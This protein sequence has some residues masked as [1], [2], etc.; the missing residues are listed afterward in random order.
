[1]ATEFQKIG[2]SDIVIGKS[3]FYSNEYYGWHPNKFPGIIL[4]PKGSNKS[5]I[6]CKMQLKLENLKTF[7]ESDG[8]INEVSFINLFLQSFFSKIPYTV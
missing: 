6:E 3:N 8:Q 4:F 5:G 7:I 1:M 2:R